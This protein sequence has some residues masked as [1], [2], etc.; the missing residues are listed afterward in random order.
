MTYFGY[1][2]KMGY[3]PQMTY[4]ANI[5]CSTEA[6][7]ASV[8]ACRHIFCQSRELERPV[9]HCIRVRTIEAYDAIETAEATHCKPDHDAQHM[10]D[11]WD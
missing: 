3:G 7:L 4:N 1:T 2:G 11:A 10:V 6:N 9:R 5:S 8:T